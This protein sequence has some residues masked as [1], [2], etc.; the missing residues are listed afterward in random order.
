MIITLRVGTEKET[1]EVFTGRL[2]FFADDELS[3]VVSAFLRV[4]MV[5]TD[6]IDE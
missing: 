3:E 2:T 4:V 6:M 5:F 1:L